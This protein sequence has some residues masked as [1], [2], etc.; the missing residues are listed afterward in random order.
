MPLTRYQE[1]SIER[2][3]RAKGPDKWVF[4]WRETT[5]GKTK[6]RARTIGTVKEFRTKADAK[7]AND[8]FRAEVN[9]S[10]DHAG[11]I[12]V[13]D[14]WGHFQANELRDPAVDRSPSTI[15]GYLDYF[16]GRIIPEWGDVALNDVK[17]VAVEKWLRDLKGAPGTK[18]KIRNLMSS[19]FSH[20]IRHELYTRANPIKS[21]RQGVGPTPRT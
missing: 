5:D 2:I 15:Q 3:K 18:A 13:S 16:K 14:A 9:A 8:N 4:R 1:G 20:C 19:L 6:H 11:K 7:R 10:R 12:T 17:A 21:V